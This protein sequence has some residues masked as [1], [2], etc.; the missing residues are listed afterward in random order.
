MDKNIKK[1]IMNPLIIDEILRALEKI[2]YGEVVIT[3]HDAKIVQ[4]ETRAKKRFV[5]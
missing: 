3:I 4:I 2:H 5:R 1:D